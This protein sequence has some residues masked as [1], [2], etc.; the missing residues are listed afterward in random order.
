MKISELIE[1]LKGAAKKHGDLPV[2][3][4]WESQV[5][6]VAAKGVGIWFARGPDILQYGGDK[7]LLIEAEG[8]DIV[9]GV[10]TETLP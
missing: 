4:T 9:G 3:C 10:D 8:F 7:V 5:R 2:A 6:L 1:L